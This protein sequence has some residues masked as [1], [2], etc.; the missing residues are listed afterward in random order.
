MRDELAEYFPF[1][2]I[3]PYDK[4]LEKKL[5]VEVFSDACEAQY[6][7]EL[8]VAPL[9]AKRLVIVGLPRTGSTFFHK[10]LALDDG[11][12]APRNVELK[13]PLRKVLAVPKK[14]NKLFS[15]IVD[16]F[17]WLVPRLRDIHFV[18]ADDPDECVQG[19]LDG[20]LPDYYVWGCFSMPSAYAFYMRTSMRAQYE[21][22]KRLL[23][24]L[25]A[26]DYLLGKSAYA[27]PTH[28]LL[29]SPHHTL[30]LDDV[31]ARCFLM[32]T[33]A[34]P[35]FGSTVIQRRLLLRAVA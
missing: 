4:I 16:A 17:F 32:I 6:R 23:T 9:P 7:D 34:A 26:Q 12:R 21:S 2:A 3:I 5:D 8:G 24:L 29:K 28:L 20:A 11:A 22:Y 10:L 19:F 31:S 27:P 15:W 14:S 1:G 33:L 18:G 25:C 35:L 13:F 30:K